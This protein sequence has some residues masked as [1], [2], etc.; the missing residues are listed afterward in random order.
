ML[1]FLLKKAAD[2]N[3]KVEASMEKVT[4]KNSKFSTSTVIIYELEDEVPVCKVIFKKD[5][6]N[7][8]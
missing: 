4:L 8:K 5:N 1:E 7:G 6:G 2:A 3:K